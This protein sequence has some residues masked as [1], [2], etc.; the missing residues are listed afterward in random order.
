[1]LSRGTEEAFKKMQMHLVWAG[2]WTTSA[3][4]DDILGE[5]WFWPNSIPDSSMLPDEVTL[6]ACDGA[7]Q[8]N[9]HLIPNGA[10]TLP[11]QHESILTSTQHELM[12]QKA[13][14]CDED[15]ALHQQHRIE[16]KRL[17]PSPEQWKRGTAPLFNTGT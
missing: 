1:M 11:M 8:A 9:R 6:N 3:L 15:E 16:W 7:D 4:T 14:T 2:D 10:A 17:V 12:L 13:F 5:I